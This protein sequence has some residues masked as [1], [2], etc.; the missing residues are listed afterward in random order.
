MTD[1]TDRIEIHGEETL[2]KRRYELRSVDLTWRR[3]DGA[4]QRMTREVY[5]K[6]NGAVILLYNRAQRTV[7]LIRQFRLP[8]FMNGY[9][10]ELVEAAAGMLDDAEP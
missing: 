4:R 5:L 1:I 3:S 7:V 6:G 10:E 9:R 8:T 2:S